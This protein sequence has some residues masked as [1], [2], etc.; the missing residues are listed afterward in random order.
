MGRRGPVAK[1]TALR[2]LDGS[3]SHH[4]RTVDAVR[5][6][7]LEQ[8]PPCPRQLSATARAAWRTAAAELVQ[9]RVLTSSD[10][11]ALEGFA[12]EYAAWREAR[13]HLVDP[14]TWVVQTPTGR[15]VPSP[16]ITIARDA[17][18]AWIRW[19]QELGLTPASR[20]RLG[21]V[22]EGEDEEATYGDFRSARP[23]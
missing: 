23:N 9:H 12:T 10:L 16:W 20:V 19:A 6:D 3:S 13:R 7:A 18:R 2:L 17:Q 11:H 5:P 22:P 8:I 4:K 21:Q 14:E 15:D 1:P